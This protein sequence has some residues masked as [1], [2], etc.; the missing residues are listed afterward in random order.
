MMKTTVKQAKFNDL[1]TDFRRFAAKK[2]NDA[3]DLTQRTV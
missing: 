3:P 2:K 1:V